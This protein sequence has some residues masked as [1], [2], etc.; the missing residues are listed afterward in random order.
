M[1]TAVLDSVGVEQAVGVN[2]AT[3]PTRDTQ[4]AP[5]RRSGDQ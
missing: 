1:N 3:R 5:R 4:A 2:A